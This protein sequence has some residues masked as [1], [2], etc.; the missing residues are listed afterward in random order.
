MVSMATKTSLVGWFEIPATDLQRAKSFYEAILEIQMTLFEPGEFRMAWFPMT[1]GA[2]RST[3]ALME[4]DSYVPSYQGTMVYLEVDDID[5]VL[6]R[7]AESGG[8]VITEKTSIGE[9]GFVGHFEDSE[10][11]RIGLHSTA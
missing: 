3:G 1:Q 9:F 8:K 5:D 10:G 2:N 7:V 4:S 6:N 11:N